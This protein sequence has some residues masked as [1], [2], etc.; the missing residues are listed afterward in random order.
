MRFLSVFLFVFNILSAQSSKKG[1]GLSEKKGF[2]QI[3]L[4]S[5]KVSWYY[6]WDL[7]SN[8]NT[9]KEFVPMLFSLKKIDALKSYKLLLAFNE[10]DHTKQANIS[11]IQAIENW[12]EIDSKV[13]KI[14]SPA[15]A[16]N[17]LKD[18]NWLDKF[19]ISN[20]KC[21]FISVHWYRG[22]NPEKFIS[23]MKNIIQKYQKPI[24]ITEFAPQT[25]SS[26]KKEPNK[27][28]QKE[29]NQFIA[30][31]CDWMNSEP[32]VYRYAWHDSKI[33]TSALFDTAGNLTET[34]KNYSSK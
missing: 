13:N 20:P 14:G 4:K 10:P 1:I 17:L 12:D 25:A 29:V 24:W 15:I 28:S 8:I 33:G 18:S 30:T 26:S 3:H 19:L 7:N 2:N 34:G 5:L 9:D 11:Y 23:D 6:N 16:G 31:V 22:C 21:D 32:M 27:Y